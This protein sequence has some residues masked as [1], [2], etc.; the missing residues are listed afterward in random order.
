MEDSAFSEQFCR[1]IH[2]AIP[3]VSAAEL[4]LLIFRHPDRW[5]TVSDLRSGLP[6]DVNITEAETS[7]CLEALRARGLVEFD[8]KK[9]TRYCAA[10]DALDTQV[11][12]LAQAYN[13]R[14]VTL[15]RMIYALR[16]SKIQSFADAFKF[17]NK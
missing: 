8:D 7:A 1:F 10:S 3:S 17:R 14:P 12:T 11:R 5:W 9:R 13:E 16:D 2:T 15:I 4:L 6:S